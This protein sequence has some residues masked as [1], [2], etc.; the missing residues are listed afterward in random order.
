MNPEMAASWI[1]F[2]AWSVLDQTRCSPWWVPPRV[3]FGRGKEAGNVKKNEWNAV[4][5]TNK[6]MYFLYFMAL[7][8]GTYICKK[9]LHV[10]TYISILVYR[11]WDRWSILWRENIRLPYKSQGQFSAQVALIIDLK[12]EFV[13]MRSLLL[14]IRLFKILLFVYF[15]YIS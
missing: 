15:L 2:T 10:N 14:A 9:I 8:Q 4:R 13:K 5:K 12:S 6:Q 7:A 11:S 3:K 1:S